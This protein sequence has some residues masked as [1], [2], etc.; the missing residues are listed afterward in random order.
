MHFPWFNSWKDVNGSLLHHY[1][2]AE[3]MHEART[4]AM[5]SVLSCIGTCKALTV[6]S[7]TPGP[8]W[9]R[10]VPVYATAWLV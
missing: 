1:L 7:E 3:T 2:T 5:S 6:H 4:L 8:A 9:L 10:L